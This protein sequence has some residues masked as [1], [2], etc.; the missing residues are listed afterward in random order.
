MPRSFDSWLAQFEA[1]GITYMELFE[2]MA[3]HLAEARHEVAPV[4][5]ALRSHGN[6]DVQFLARTL[7]ESMDHGDKSGSSFPMSTDQEMA[8]SDAKK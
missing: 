8:H 4:L 2:K 3:L 7:A 1:G 5:S 6:P